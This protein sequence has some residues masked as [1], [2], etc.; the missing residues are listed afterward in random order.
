[1]QS[2]KILFIENRQKTFFWE[3]LAIKLLKKGFKISWIVQNHSFKPDTGLSHIIP[4]PSKKEKIKSNTKLFQYISSTD[5]IINYFQGDSHHYQYYYNKIHEIIL[6]TKPDY[7]IGESTLFHE[8]IS[9]ALAKQLNIPFFAPCSVAYPKGRFSFFKF[10]SNLTEGGDKT[11]LNNSEIDSIIKNIKHNRSLPSYIKKDLSKSDYIDS[12]SYKVSI[13]KPY[14]F[15]ERYNTP[16]PFKKYLRNKETKKNLFLWNQLA[17]K[18][19]LNNED[20]KILLF[21]L[22]FQPEA[23]LDVHGNKFRD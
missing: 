14:I 9:S 8:I 20:K 7:I 3:K 12:I 10:D 21:P 23:N 11:S 2:K 5:R 1:V 19:S 22:Q 4:Y 13:L 15:G 17:K 16:S 6:Q 18:K